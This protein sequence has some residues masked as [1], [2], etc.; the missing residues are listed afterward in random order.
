LNSKEHALSIIN[1]TSFKMEKIYF[2]FH[3]LFTHYIVVAKK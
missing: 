1:N 2:S 3:D